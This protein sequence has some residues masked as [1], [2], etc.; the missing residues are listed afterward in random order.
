MLFS[1]VTESYLRN[2]VIYDGLHSDP[3]PVIIQI[4]AVEN[5]NLFRPDQN[6]LVRE[7]R[8]CLSCFNCLFNYWYVQHLQFDNNFNFPFNLCSFI[9]Q[10]KMIYG[11]L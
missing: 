4:P 3:P 7:I 6:R 2:D 1:H 5:Q 11:K 8:T 10:I 9:S